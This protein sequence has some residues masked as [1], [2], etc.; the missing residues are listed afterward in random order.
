MMLEDLMWKKFAPGEDRTRT[1]LVADSGA[2][3]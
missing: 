2:T 3:D 1:A